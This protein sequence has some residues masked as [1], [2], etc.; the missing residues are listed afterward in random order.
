MDTE[1][2]SD[3][4]TQIKGSLPVFHLANKQILVH[5]QYWMSYRGETKINFSRNLNMYTTETNVTVKQHKQKYH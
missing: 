4:V 5:L 1:F 2:G 3:I